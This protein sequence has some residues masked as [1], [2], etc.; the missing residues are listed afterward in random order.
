MIRRVRRR[1]FLAEAGALSLAIAVPSAAGGG[2]VDALLAPWTGPYGGL[3]PFDKVHVEAFSPALREGMEMERVEIA[4]IARNPAPASFENTIVALENVGRP[5]RRV[6]S[7]FNTYSGTM[8]VGPMRA[9]ETEMSPVLAAFGDEIVQNG[10][11]FAR[12]K[13]VYDAR[14]NAGLTPEQQRLAT[15]VYDR[16]A[17]QGAALDAA[18]KSRLAQINQQLAR[19][20]TT[21]SQNQLADEEGYTLMLERPEDLAGMPES[22]RASAARAAAEHGRPG[23]WAITNTRSSMEPFLTYASRRDLREKGWRMWIMRGDNA[24]A[25]DNKPVITQIMQLRAEKATLLGHPTYAHWITAAN[26]AKTPDAAM[27]LMMQVWPAAVARVHQ[28]VADMQAVVDA[29]HG[30]FNIAP[31]DYRYYAEKVRKAKYDLDQDE[32]KGYLQLEKIREGMFGLP[33]SSTASSSSLRPT[34]RCIRRTCAC[35]RCAGPGP[36]SACGISIRTLATAR[37]PARG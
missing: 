14:E 28:E 1:E 19:L 17:R 16:F 8:N 11:L 35:T 34:C 9:L 4:A 37:R 3:P 23:A 7:L 36:V 15:V 21:F 12:V 24:G 29:E 10:A 13:A 2:D 6:R 18:H 31:W 30:G 22:L 20:Y 26:M 32:V 25:H 27:A 33:A 5:L